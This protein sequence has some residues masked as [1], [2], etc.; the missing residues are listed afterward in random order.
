MQSDM[1]YMQ[2]LESDMEFPRC[3]FIIILHC[4]VN[5]FY[6]LIC[7]FCWPT[8]SLHWFNGTVLNVMPLEPSNCLVTWKHAFLVQALVVSFTLAP[9]SISPLACCLASS[10]NRCGIVCSPTCVRVANLI[11][12]YLLNAPA[13]KL[14][15]AVYI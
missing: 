10:N 2:L 7:Q 12:Q 11:L 1:V 3:S 15:V 6:H 14:Y 8:T 13:M 9:C 4:S 5:H